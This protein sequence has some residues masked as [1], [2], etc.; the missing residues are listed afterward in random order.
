MIHIYKNSPDC[1]TKLKRVLGITGLNDTLI[2]IGDGVLNLF[3]ANAPDWPEGVRICCLENDLQARGLS[4]P[5]CGEVITM[6]LFVEIVASDLN[7]PV[8]W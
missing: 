4:N 6:E 7:S 8:S 1:I 5:S 3:N 2:F